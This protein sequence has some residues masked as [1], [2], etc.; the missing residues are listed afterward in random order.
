M[1]KGHFYCAS[2]SPHQS[3]ITKWRTSL[4]WISGDTTYHYIIQ[5]PKMMVMELG[6]FC[7]YY[8]NVL[9]K[10]SLCKKVLF[11]GHKYRLTLGWKYQWMNEQHSCPRLRTVWRFGVP[12]WSHVYQIKNL[13]CGTCPLSAQCSTLLAQLH[14]TFGS[15]CTQSLDTI[16]LSTYGS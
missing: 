6:I 10:Y 3:G 2:F 7:V 1:F 11:T 15:L 5:G 16:I 13:V 8:S 14:R 12:D 4:F 9:V